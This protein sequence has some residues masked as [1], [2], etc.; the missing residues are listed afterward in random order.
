MNAKVR[1]NMSFYD[2]VYIIDILYVIFCVFYTCVPK[3]GLSLL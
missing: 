2:T 3:P 1:I